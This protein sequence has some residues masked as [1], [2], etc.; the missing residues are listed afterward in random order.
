MFL[1]E[2]ADLKNRFM[3]RLEVFHFLDEEE[4]DIELFNGRMDHDKCISILETLIDPANVSAFFICGPGPMMDAAEAALMAKAVPAQRIFIERFTI[5]RPSA[6][7]LAVSKD[8]EQKADGFKII[9]TL[10]GRRRAVAFSAD[11]G[12]ILD[13]ARAA[14]MSVPYACKAGVCA[15]CR[16]KVLHGDVEMK[17][18]YGLSDDEV[19]QGYVLTCQAVPKS[20]D[21]IIDYDG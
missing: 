5:G 14:G 15:T 10:E 8:L 3:G 13:S 2:L 21:V 7:V 20:A 9:I 17:V 16:A 18:N 4:E 6:A 1:D 12:N 11:A 19:A